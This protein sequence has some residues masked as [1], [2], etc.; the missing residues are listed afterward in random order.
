AGFTGLVQLTDPALKREMPYVAFLPNG[1]V[2]VAFRV[3]VGLQQSGIAFKHA[4]SLQAI[5]GASE[6]PI[7]ATPTDI[8][9]NPYVVVVPLAAGI[10]CSSGSISR[11]ARG[12]SAGASTPRHGPKPTPP[13][14]TPPASRSR[15]NRP[16]ESRLARFRRCSARTEPS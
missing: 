13:G 11:A 3:V 2:V 15:R 14:W 10:S 12:S 8:Q 16:T 1:D 4:S 5:T 7:D 6:V 9:W